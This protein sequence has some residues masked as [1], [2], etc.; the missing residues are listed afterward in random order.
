MRAIHQGDPQPKRL[1]CSAHS[2]FRQALDDVASAAFLDKR[3]AP[4]MLGDFGRLEPVSRCRALP[5][6][7]RT[8]ATKSA[9]LSRSAASSPEP[10]FHSFMPP[11][12]VLPKYDGAS[13]VL[14]QAANPLPRAEIL[15]VRR[16]LCACTLA[17]KLVTAQ[18]APL[19]NA[20]TLSE[21]DPGA[22]CT[23]PRRAECPPP[24][25][26][27]GRVRAG[28]QRR[29]VFRPLLEQLIPAVVDASPGPVR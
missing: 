4:G 7:R 6:S 27:P 22:G 29:R 14:Q 3:L 11:N 15:E 17:I 16:G 1:G 20:A 24:A 25:A 10:S 26:R 21:R 28:G 13:R 18:A 19:E 5:E 23:T 2:A 9:T 8:S 12:F